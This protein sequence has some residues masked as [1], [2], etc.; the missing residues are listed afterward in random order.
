MS[1]LVQLLDLSLA[2]SSASF[3]CPRLSGA[4]TSRSATSATIICPSAL[5]ARLSAGVNKRTISARQRVA[6]QER[7]RDIAIS[8]AADVSHGSEHPATI[9]VVRM[10]G[11]HC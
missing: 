3:P 9:A 4:C 7:D 1:V 2:S 11:N 8:T 6:K 5:Q 10:S